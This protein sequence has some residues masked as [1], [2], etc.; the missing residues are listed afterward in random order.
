MTQKQEAQKRNILSSIPILK[1]FDKKDE[2]NVLSTVDNENNL[3]TSQPKKSLYQ[4]QHYS[5]SYKNELPFTKHISKCSTPD[6]E[7][8]P[9]DENMICM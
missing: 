4:C 2:I 5:K 7:A 3:R 9:K 8:S 1:F 6:D